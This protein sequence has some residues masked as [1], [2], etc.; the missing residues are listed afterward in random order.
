MNRAEKRRNEKRSR[1]RAKKENRRTPSDADA[2]SSG[3]VSVRE[4][5]KLSPSRKVSRYN[6]GNAWF[7]SRRFD[8][9]AECYRDALKTT[10]DAYTVHYNLGT[11]LVNLGR[12]DEAAASFREAVR[13][14]PNFFEAHNSLGAVLMRSG[15]RDEAITSYRNALKCNPDS[16]EAHNNLAVALMKRGQLDEAE[17]SFRRALKSKPNFAE[18]HG[19]LGRLHRAQGRYDLAMAAFREALRA[20]PTSVK[21]LVDLGNIHENLGQLD[22]AQAYADQALAMDDTGAEAHFLMGIVHQQRSQLS[23]AVARFR[24]ALKLSPH[25]EAAAENIRLARYYVRDPRDV[26]SR[27]RERLAADP[28]QAAIAISLALALWRQGKLDAAGEVLSNHAD[29]GGDWRATVHLGALRLA[30][31]RL[32]EAEALV[33]R[34]LEA[35]PEHVHALAAKASILAAR[36]RANA[37]AASPAPSKVKAKRVALHMGQ[38]FHYGILRPVLDACSGEHE[39][40]LTPHA[41]AL[42]DFRPDVVVTAD[43]H[44]SY[45]RAWLPDALFVWVRHGLISKNTSYLASRIADFACMPSEAVCDGY[46]AHGG[47]P[48]RDFWATG[49]V[50]MD[51]LFRAE[52]SPPRVAQKNGKRVVLYA[53]TW[54]ATLSSAPMLG[55]RVVELIRGRRRDVTLVIKPHPVIADRNPEWIETWRA[56]AAREENVELVEDPSANIMPYLEAAD[57]LISDASSVIFEFLALDRPIILISNPARHGTAHFD[58][59]GIE[60]RWRDV[61]EELDDVNDLPC[62]VERALDDP[63]ANAKRRADYRL[64]LFGEY[65]D[66]RAA[67][68]IAEKIGAL[69]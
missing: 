38:S 49:Y 57:L 41:E 67:E 5:A 15:R 53:P 30:Q 47:T 52:R 66:G 59:T 24:H 35:G 69:P 18:A 13:F 2:R 46:A 32:D 56:L 29:A 42:V 68:R 1:T 4:A 65:T 31:G 9:A 40:L 48:R 22:E 19:N 33:Y 16:A 43:S 58:A 27:C 23:E 17:T 6:Q 45:L 14:N 11:T 51:S 8:E 37:S 26:E 62:A 61:G 21:A 36:S 3:R 39:V 55:S 54:N 28:E 10:P 34:A 12:W 7:Q 44:I 63:G 50:Q 25:L 60:W 64:R 20:R